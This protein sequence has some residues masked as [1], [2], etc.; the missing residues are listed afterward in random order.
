MP[1][2]G[3]SLLSSTTVLFDKKKVRKSCKI[4]GGS[5]EMDVMAG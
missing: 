2:L 4:I 1:L 3:G 5:Q